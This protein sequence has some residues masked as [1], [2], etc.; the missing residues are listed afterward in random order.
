ML[1]FTLNLHSLSVFSK[2]IQIK[3]RNQFFLTNVVFIKWRSLCV[4]MEAET[5]HLWACADLVESMNALFL[6][7]DC[8]GL[9]QVSLKNSY[10][11][12]TTHFATKDRK[13][14]HK[15]KKLPLMQYVVIYYLQNLHKKSLNL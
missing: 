5:T 10:L 3:C 8:F 15:W 9:N 11:Q 6:E 7:Q 14:S 1:L 2:G 13:E 12:Q 4:K